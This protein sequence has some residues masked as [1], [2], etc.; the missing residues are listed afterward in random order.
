MGTV[1]ESVRV[2]D[3]P[4]RGHRVPPPARVGTFLVGVGSR[5]VQPP[6][7]AVVW[8]TQIETSRLS[9]DFSMVYT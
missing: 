3:N 9:L 8:V 6:L 1:V 7:G 2:G 4:S 5:D